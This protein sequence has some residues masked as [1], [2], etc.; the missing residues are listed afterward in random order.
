MRAD[1]LLVDRPTGSEANDGLETL[2]VGDVPAVTTMIVDGRIVAE[3]ARNTPL[4]DRMPSIELAPTL[5]RN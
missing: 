5:R 1:L 3:R 2:K 4:T